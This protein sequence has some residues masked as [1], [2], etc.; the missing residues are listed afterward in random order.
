MDLFEL[1]ERQHATFSLAQARDLGLTDDHVRGMVDRGVAERAA[2]AVYRLR[3]TPPTWRQ[4]LSVATLSIPGSMASHRAAARLRHL[5][6]FERAPVELLVERGAKRRRQPRAAVLHETLDLKAPDLDEVDGIACTSLVRTLVDLPAVAHEFKAGVALDQALRVDP[7][8]LLRV[9]HRHREVAR[10]GRDGTVAPRALL[11]ERGVGELV[12][13]GFERRALRLIDQGGLP[14]PVTQHHVIHGDFECRLD[15]AWPEPLV[16]M[17]CDSLRYHM[18]ERAFRW[19]RRRRRGLVALGWTVLEF[20][21][22]EVTQEGPM[23]LRELERHL[24][25]KRR[26]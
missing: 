14:K 12:D 4:R 24:T 17:E 5:D 7:A 1:A 23:V 8:V 3:G 6:G 16:A 20:T 21:F 10:K 19:E 25:P 18:G 2:P 9:A 22:R 15:I 26:P 13:S 11:A